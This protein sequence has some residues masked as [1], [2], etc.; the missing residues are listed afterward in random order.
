MSLHTSTGR[1]FPV[2]CWSDGP[3]HPSSAAQ[4]LIACV[5]AASALSQA[6]LKEEAKSGIGRRQK[7]GLG[8]W[9]SCLFSHF[10]ECQRSQSACN[11]G[12][13]R[14]PGDKEGRERRRLLPLLSLHG[15]PLR[16]KGRQTRILLKYSQLGLRT[17]QKE[18]MLLIN[19][20]L[21]TAETRR[22][23]SCTFSHADSLMSDSTVVLF[24]KLLYSGRR[25]GFLPCA[26]LY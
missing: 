6:G 26:A 12:R 8:L 5:L 15:N 20:A 21:Q 25:G 7:V 22:L 3:G 23:G 10:S 9:E 4:Q 19:N 1:K 17:L 14:S 24:F 13:E 16:N 2:A 18:E 11:L